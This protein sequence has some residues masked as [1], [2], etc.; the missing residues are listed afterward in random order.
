[1][2]VTP[3]ADSTGNKCNNFTEFSRD[4]QPNDSTEFS[5][6]GPPVPPTIPP[7]MIM[8]LVFFICYHLPN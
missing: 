7:G 2:E 1:M 5:Y 8:F 3:E 4:D 6:E